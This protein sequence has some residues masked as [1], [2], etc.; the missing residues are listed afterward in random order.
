[1]NLIF[2]FLI[3]ILMIEII[4]GYG[5]YLK[6]STLLSGHYVSSTIMSINKILEIYNKNSDSSENEVIKDNPKKKVIDKK[7]KK[8]SDATQKRNEA[9]AK[10]R[11]EEESFKINKEKCD[12]YFSQNQHIK[13]SGVTSFKK[14]L[15]VQTYLD[16]LNL[17]DEKTDYLIIIVGNSETFGTLK[18]V[19]NRLHVKLQRNLR[20]ELQSKKIFVV[21]IAYPGGLISDHLRDLVSF[22]ELYKPDLAI[23]YTG[24]NEL[25]MTET[26]ETFTKKFT[27]NKKNFA[28]YDFYK[29]G[30]IIP[31]NVR[32]CLDKNKYFTK[33]NFDQNDQI[34]NINQHITS[35]YK[36][37]KNKLND[38]S[39]DF[40][41]YIQPFNKKMVPSKNAEINFPKI[42]NLN[43]EDS[44]FK[45]LN[46]TNLGTE[47][48]FIDL[49]H[50]K[51]SEKI[52]QKLTKDILDIYKK[53]IL[54]KL[55][56]ENN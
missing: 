56:N 6:N 3:I 34:L 27:I 32:Y 12:N 55:N 41:F 44:N 42:V 45:N 11:E 35:H 37:I 1:M 23:F 14:P 46:L 52:S 25:I 18:K 2:R 22:S 28:T 5:H 30:L 54:K 16:F 8:I 47:L 9:L 19:D 38:N 7:E 51:D 17:Y 50:T 13:V 31:N 39:V 53:K 33:I 49:F 10:Q 48:N 36:K 20:N 29:N 24:G 21:N 4:L 43:I 15:D 26:Y 40:L